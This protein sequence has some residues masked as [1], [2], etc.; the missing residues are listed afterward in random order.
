MQIN[1]LLSDSFETDVNDNI[2]EL[3]TLFRVKYTVLKY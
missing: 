2:E 3:N 1:N